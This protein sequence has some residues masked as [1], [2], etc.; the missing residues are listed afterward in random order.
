MLGST[1]LG[2]HLPG[3]QRVVIVDGLRRWET[4][5]QPGEV[6]IRIDTIGLAGLDER[7]E[8]GARVRTVDGV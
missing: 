1:E 6:S 3:R 8:I 2:R 4:L 5:E 7:I